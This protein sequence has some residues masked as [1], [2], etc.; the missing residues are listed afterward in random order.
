M[1]NSTSWMHCG[2][3]FIACEKHGA[4][5]SYRAPPLRWNPS[6]K[7]RQTSSSRHAHAGH[8]WVAAAGGGQEIISPDGPLGVIG[9]CRPEFRHAFGGDGATLSCQT[10]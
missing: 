9:S 5:S 1:T 10:V 7:R 2:A 8:G 4:W 6:P 3:R